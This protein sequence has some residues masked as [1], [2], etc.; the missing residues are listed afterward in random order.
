MQNEGTAAKNLAVYEKQNHVNL[1][2]VDARLFNMSL[3][4]NILCIIF[5]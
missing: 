3:V 1:Q 5:L 4:S 2:N